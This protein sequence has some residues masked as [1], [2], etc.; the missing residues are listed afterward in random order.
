MYR[1]QAKRGYHQTLE[2]QQLNDHDRSEKN[3]RDIDQAINNEMKYDVIDP[4]VSAGIAFGYDSQYKGIAD[5]ISK[6]GKVSGSIKPPEI[7]VTTPSFD[8][9][10]VTVRPHADS[11]ASR[12][13]FNKYEVKYGPVR[14]DEKENGDDDEKKAN[15]SCNGTKVIEINSV[16]GEVKINGLQPGTQYLFR[17]R[18]S[19]EQIGFTDYSDVVTISTQ[20]FLT[21]DRNRHGEGVT[22]LSNLRVRYPT[23]TSHCINLVDYVVRREAHDSFEWSVRI[24]G[25]GNYSWIGF[26]N[27][28][29]VGNLNSYLG[30]DSSCQCSVGV[31]VNS[32]TLRLQGDCKVSSPNL[33]IS[34]LPKIG[35]VLKLTV[36]FRQR[37]VTLRFNNESLGV[38]WQNIYDALIPAVA[39]NLREQNAAEYSIVGTLPQ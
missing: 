20:N 28:M 33:T 23:S 11:S 31:V 30:A 16:D 34:H 38:I 29:S 24:H 37:Q 15:H 3:L 32:R 7:S 27:A 19:Y 5:R 36:D 14:D 8:E 18:A 12:L 10:T 9:C 39:G 22:F 1:C 26:V 25:I 35:D 2:D 6:F 21:W 17:V 4:I 13:K